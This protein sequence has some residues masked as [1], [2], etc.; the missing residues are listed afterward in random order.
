MAWETEVQGDF[1]VE[2]RMEVANQ[3]GALATVAAT[4]AEMDANID[5]VIMEERDGR[6]S[7][8]TLLIEVHDRRHLAR[9]MRRVR[10]LDMVAKITRT[11]G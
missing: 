3:R 11:R 1:P 6:Y 2:I 7:A 8:L 4:V 10:S 9:I 5:N